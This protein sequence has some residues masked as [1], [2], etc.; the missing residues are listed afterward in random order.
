MQAGKLGDGPGSGEAVA[1]DR[2][3]KSSGAPCAVCGY[4]SSDGGPSE[5][6]SQSMS[7]IRAVLPAFE[8]VGKRLAHEFKNPLNAIFV[9]AGVHMLRKA[10][11]HA[12][13][14][15]RAYKFEQMSCSIA[16]KLH[17]PDVHINLCM[18]IRRLPL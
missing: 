9:L 5:R 6:Q 15:D 11:L 18:Q 7:L 3:G 10:L 8:D 14:P 2:S 4:S 12:Q 1:S 13:L 17:M 16:R